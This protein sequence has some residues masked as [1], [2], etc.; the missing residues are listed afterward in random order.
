MVDLCTGRKTSRPT[1][2]R[3]RRTRRVYGWPI[4]ACSAR[5]APT[6]PCARASGILEGFWTCARP[7]RRRS[8]AA[9][10][11]PQRGGAWIGRRPSRRRRGRRL[12]R[13]SRPTRR[14]DLLPLPLARPFRVKK[15]ISLVSYAASCSARRLVPQVALRPSSRRQ[16][17]GRIIIYRAHIDPTKKS[18]TR[19]PSAEPQADHRIFWQHPCVAA[20]G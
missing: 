14:T 6:R 16:R 1:S 18:N 2:A 7:A 15:Y 12:S 8:G 5:T 17:S 19:S 11:S 20:I 4:H 9:R 3:G 10:T 13:R